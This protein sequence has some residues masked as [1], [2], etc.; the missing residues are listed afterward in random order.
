HRSHEAI[1]TNHDMSR[2]KEIAFAFLDPGRIAYSSTIPVLASRTPG[3]A[4]KPDS[5]QVAGRSPGTQEFVFP[6]SSFALGR[7]GATPEFL[8]ARSAFSHTS[9]CIPLGT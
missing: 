7:F 3:K 1:M 5:V 2:L 9:R 8:S 4:Q 6:G